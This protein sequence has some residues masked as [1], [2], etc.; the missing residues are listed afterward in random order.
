MPHTIVPCCAWVGVHPHQDQDAFVCWSATA[1][2][3]CC[4]DQTTPSARRPHKEMLIETN[5]R[6]EMLSIVAGGDMW[7]V[8]W[9]GSIRRDLRLV[10]LAHSLY[11]TYL[12][13]EHDYSA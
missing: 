12:P 10:E 13:T 5:T 2:L 9:L 8:G 6:L 7:S 4:P 1:T 11:H 3:Y